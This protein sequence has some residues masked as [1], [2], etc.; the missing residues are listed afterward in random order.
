MLAFSVMN[1]PGFAQCTNTAVP[2]KFYEY[3]IVAQTGSCNGNTF[4]SLGSNPAINDFGQVGF[5]GQASAFAGS[6]LWVGDGHSH[7]ATTPINPNS[8]GSSE[9]YDGAVQLTTNLSSL[10]LVS[11]DS[12][13]TTSPA[14]TSIRVWNTATPDSF[15]YA[16]RGGPGQQFGAVFPFPSINKNGDTAFTALDANNPSQKYLVEV[17]SAGVLSK[18]GVKLSV[19][20]PMIDDNGNVVLYQQTTSPS[21][22]FQIVFYQKGLGSFTTIADYNSFTSIDSAPGI[23]HD[24]MVIAFQGNLSAAGATA[25]NM[26]PGPGIFAATNEG[27]GV[28]HITRIT[29]IQVE[30]P[31]SGGNGD[32]ICDPGEICQPAAELGFDAAGN[33]ISFSPTGYAIQTRVAVTNLALG[34][35]GIDDDTFVISFVGTPTAASRSNPVLKNGTPLFFSSQQGLW[36]IRIDVQHELSQATTRVYHPRTAIPVVQINDKISGSVITG[37]GAFD[38]VAN[39]AKDESG[40]IRTMRRGDHRV[41]FWASTAA[42]GQLIARANHLDSDQDGLLDHWES[43][44][45][46]MD[47]D[48]VV[49]LNLADMGAS[50]TKRDVFLEIDWVLDQPA[51]SFQPAPGVISAAP[52]QGAMSPLESMFNKAPALSGNQYGARI[53]GASPASIS[54]GIITHVDGGPGNDKAGAPFSIHMG[55]GPLNGG[56]QIGENGSSGLPELIY[57]GQP[58]SVTIPGVNTRGFQDVKD[59]FLGSQDKDG[60]ELAFHYVVFGDYYLIRSDANNAMSWHVTG[61]GVNYLDSASALPGSNAGDIVKITGGKGAGQYQPINSFDVSHNRVYVDANWTTVPDATSTFSIFGDS[62]GLSEVFIN[63]TPDFNSLPGNDLMVTLGSASIGYFGGIVNGLLGTAC[64]Q[65]RT[66]AHELGH[67]LGLRHGGIDNNANKNG[68]FQSIMS[69]DYQLKCNPPSSVVSYSSSNTVFNDWANLQGNFSD[70]A[71]HL[72]N[73]IGKAFGTFS[74]LNQESEEQGVLAY[75]TQNGAYDNQPPKVAVQ[76]P[77]A[78]AKVGLTLALQVTVNATDNAQVASV[79]VSFDVNGN[80]VIDPNELITAKSSG[81][82]T[83]KIRRISRPSPEIRGHAPSLRP[84]WTLPAIRARHISM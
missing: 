64:Q 34:A 37:I 57:F 17:T 44:G 35:S 10:Q 63:P 3:Y 76:S 84:Q 29:G 23:S 21:T 56:D 1:A 11:K 40:N 50:P 28:W 49:D 41:V 70:S 8:T 2:G 42:G 26:Y 19:G 13:T 43:T 65:W 72:G 46:D 20:E 24:G 36:T 22:G 45:I 60:R 18:I 48:G 59:N 80:G 38:D 33:P 14:T 66:L 25:L 55:T 58:G 61:G 82:N 81:A 9:I 31:N 51:Y 53:D 15:R 16:A 32:G 52:G 78:N 71:I 47:Q 73:T 69:Y 27:G 83:Y 67:T 68:T 12:I 7:P 75:I 5:M 4:T 74:E 62:S 77:A 54:A 6:A 79:T 30:T 39:A